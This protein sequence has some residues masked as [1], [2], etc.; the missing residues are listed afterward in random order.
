M[1]IIDVFIIL[2][3]LFGGAVG[4]KR[5]FTKQLVCSIGFIV[6][7]ILSF[8]LK[9]PIS[10]FFYEHLPFFKFSG[11]IKGVTA[12]NIALYEVMAFVLVFT[13]LTI[14]FR[15]VILA[16]SV[17]E[18]ILKATI[19]L[20]IP[21]KI[22]GAILG[23]LE[24]YLVVF[25]VLYILSFPTLNADI[26]NKSKYRKPILN[27]TPIISSKVKGNVK[28]IDDFNDLK[29]KY[30][31]EKNPKK[32]NKKTLDIFLKYDIIT[33]KSVD[34]LIDNKKLD[35]NKNDKMLE[36]YRKEG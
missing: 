31:K 20:G 5:G 24:N 17:F 27:N 29:K 15:L 14:I 35:I 32:F 12:L 13:V 30:E 7:V 11:V 16:T 1:S 2:F 36:K 21:S 10:I 34:Y 28:V 8:L 23:F 22:L 25:S 33:I 3:V 26:L 19:I 9:N 6:I 18:K 4:F